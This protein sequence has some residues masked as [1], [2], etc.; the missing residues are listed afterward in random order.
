MLHSTPSA[1]DIAKASNFF[2]EK[3]VLKKRGACSAN[4]FTSVEALDRLIAELPLF[5]LSQTKQ[6]KIQIEVHLLD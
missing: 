6:K 5:I 3:G 4:I 2:F 1:D